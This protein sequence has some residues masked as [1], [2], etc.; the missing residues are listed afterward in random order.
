MFKHIRTKLMLWF[1][2]LA[3]V[4]LLIASFLSYNQT[5]SALIEKE[6]QS[7]QQI[8]IS[9]TQGMDEWLD[10]RMSEIQLAAKTDILQSGDEERIT[11]YLKQLFEQSSEVY[12]NVLFADANGVI[13]ATSSKGL[14]VDVSD[15]NYFIRAKEGESSYSEIILSRETDE[16]TFTITAPVYNQKGQFSGAIFA[17]VNFEAF[18]NHFFGNIDLG[19]WSGKFLLVDEL[20]IVQFIDNEELLGAPIDHD[21]FGEEFT[22]LLRKG[23]EEAG[24]DTYVAPSGEENLLAFSPVHETNYS[25]FLSI[26]MEHILS[27]A[28]LVQNSML[29]IIFTTTIIVIVLAFYYSRTIARPISSIT[30]HVK[31]IAT[32]DLTVP[33]L[34]E[35]GKDE[36][37]ILSKFVNKMSRSL[38]QMVQQIADISQT[39]NSQSE[40]LTQ[41]ANEVKI[42]AEQVAATME[43]MAAGSEEQAS[44]SN[45]ISQLIENLNQQISQSNDEGKVLE[46]SS[47]KVFQLSNEGKNEM[48][49]SVKLMSEITTVVTD[50]VD[51]VKTLE[52][53]SLEISKLVD[54]IQDI[55]E[56]T[57]LLALNAA[58]EA[59]RAGESGKGFAVVAEEV[60]KLA[61]QVGGNVTEISDIITGIQQETKMVVKSLVEGFKKVE[62][63]NEQIR[64]SREIFHTINDAVTNM[65]DRIENIS[66]NLMNIST[67]S[68][69][70]SEQV[71]EIASASEEAAAGIEESSATAEQQSASL[72]EITANAETLSQLSEE[73]N[74]LIT[75]FK[76]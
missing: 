29:A 50:S 22:H 59:A 9:T 6:Q 33:E 67:N 14:G 25:V 66:S 2:A 43:Q 51:K 17:G 71:A 36:I 56:Q 4:P 69:K 41:S 42:G 38:R 63:G 47:N 52:E 26:P 75:Q 10:R 34:E 48:G 40:E 35:K 15:R 53:H 13:V 30:D 64:M 44:S 19:N 7:A 49:Q 28:K 1:L 23:S 70:V 62:A 46:H 72:Q 73:L 8:V 31:R 37:A 57:N 27:S 24:V 18:L 68:N 55:S 76:L 60:R 5:A 12:E 21:R 58:I 16:R 39:V 54:V 11:A 45:E 3:I 74:R 20:A 61:E 65:N 32:G